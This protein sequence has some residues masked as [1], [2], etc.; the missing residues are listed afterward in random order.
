MR[1]IIP[2]PV[3]LIFYIGIAIGLDFLSPVD[4]LLGNARLPLAI[5]LAVLGIAVA[6]LGVMEFRRRD[7]TI[8][9]YKIDA[10]S[11]LVTSGVYRWTRNPMY[12]GLLLVLFGVVAYSQDVLALLAPAAFIVTLNRLQIRPE[13]RAMLQTFGEAYTAYEA[14]TRRWI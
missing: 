11:T 5:L 13:E 2:P 1:P 10:A 9:P 4:L 7:T 14:R 3:I 8:N 12:L 6:V